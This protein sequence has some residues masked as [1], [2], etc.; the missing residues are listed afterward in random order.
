[1]LITLDLSGD[2][3]TARTTAVTL[4]ILG[5]GAYLFNCR[6]LNTSAFTPR[7]LTGNPT[8]WIS[9]GIMMA[10]HLLFTYAPF[11]QAWF[12]S[13]P[14][15]ILPW[16]LAAGFSALIFLIVEAAK[17]WLRQSH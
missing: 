15:G 6:L 3:P 4:L 16:G 14:I 17:A 12:A 9:V 10:L 13:A 7:V 1:F 5:Q 11:M 2:L 8:I